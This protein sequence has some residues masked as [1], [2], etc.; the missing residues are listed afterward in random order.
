MLS[1]K[2]A[3][4]LATCCCLSP[5]QHAMKLSGN[6][7]RQSPEFRGLARVTAMFED[8]LTSPKQINVSLLGLPVCMKKQEANTFP[9]LLYLSCSLT[10]RIRKSRSSTEI[11]VN[12]ASSQN[13]YQLLSQKTLGYGNNFSLESISDW[14]ISYLVQIMHLDFLYI[15]WDSQ[16]GN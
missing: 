11:W 9:S 4:L 2:S 12:P 14:I 7:A 3:I 13:Q 5:Q 16:N 1:L 6:G 15:L 10:T 8:C